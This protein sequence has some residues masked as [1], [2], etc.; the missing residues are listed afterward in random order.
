MN[1]TSSISLK[2]QIKLL[3]FVSLLLSFLMGTHISHA[4]DAIILP[5]NMSPIDLNV[6][7]T[8]TSSSLPSLSGLISIG[9]FSAAAS[10]DDLGSE[11]ISSGNFLLS[12]K[13]LLV[14]KTT[15]GEVSISEHSIVLL[16]INGQSMSLYCL[17]EA[18][19]KGTKLLTDGKLFS[20]SSG[21]HL[22]ITNLKIDKFASVNAVAEISHRKIHSENT[23]H[24]TLYKSEFNIFTAINHSRLRNIFG[25]PKNHEQKVLV[26]HLLKMAAIQ[27]NLANGGG[28]MIQTDGPVTFQFVTQ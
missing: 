25:S 28:R 8:G 22:T 27:M 18:H 2:L 10:S 24:Y 11:S 26:N 4:R 5:V 14:I 15:F 19:S 17:D 3:F 1:F 16:C 6:S 21:D 20:L 9:I 23:E 12:P 13:K 7:K